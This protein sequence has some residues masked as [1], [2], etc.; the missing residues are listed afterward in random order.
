MESVLNYGEEFGWEIG[1]DFPEW[2]NNEEYVRTI[3][4]GY[5]LDGETP[6]RAYKRVTKTIAA[7]LEKPWLAARFFDYIW[8]GWLSLASPVLANTGTERGLP[9]SCFGLSVSDNM[10]DIG[11]K[12]LEMMVLAKHG[13]GVGT[14]YSKLRPAGTSIKDNGTSDGVVPFC[15]I[16]D[17]TIIATNQGGVRKGAAVINLNIEHGDFDDF[18]GIREPLGDV[19]RQCLNINTS[20][21]IPDSFMQKVID[22]DPEAR[23]R[24]TELI[25][26]RKKKGQP[27]IVFEDTVNRGNPKAYEKNGLK[28]SN[29]NLCSEIVLFNDEFHSFVC[30]LASLN[31]YKFDEWADST[32]VEDSIKFLDGVMEEF[33]QRAKKLKGFENAVRSAEKGRAL[34]LGVLGW[35]SYLQDR[36]IPFTSLQARLHTNK[37][38]TLIQERSIA[39]S[40]KLARKLGEPEWCKRTGMRNTH[41]LAIA[42]TTSN[43]KLA[44]GMSP[45]I[46]PWAANLFT[47]PCS[48]G[49]LRRRNPILTKLLAEIGENKEDIWMKINADSGSVRSLDFLDEYVY[50]NGA[51]YHKTDTP[52][53]SDRG[54]D[55]SPKEVFK[56]FREID[57]KGIVLQAAFRQ[58][59]IDQSQSLNLAFFAD[60]SPKYISDVHMLAWKEGV[61]TLY[62]LRSES[63]LKGDVHREGEDCTWCE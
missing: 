39:A 20:A 61:K 1:V 37:I 21:V 48:Q 4:N 47:E 16:V 32:L 41:L 27:Y 29:T 40:K 24:Y 42:P 53:G 55:V 10:Y 9:I 8:K 15:K 31:L 43:S 33:I 17:S 13:G 62:Y 28:V 5:L 11:N 23:N 25:R 34:G 51:L 44:G 6:K 46:E 22:G 30:C 14:C 52:I 49:V 50:N 18:L 59:F 60:E 58:R 26:M 45:G 56:T 19:N 3:S 38:F 7:R 36:G 12:N 63:V 2:G 57:Q 35:H 54:N